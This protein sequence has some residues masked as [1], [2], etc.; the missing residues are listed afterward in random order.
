MILFLESKLNILYP[1][2]RQSGSNRPY[3]IT[4]YVG[5]VVNY[6]DFRPAIMW[7]KSLCTVSPQERSIIERV[8]I[9]KW[10]FCQLLCSVVNLLLWKSRTLEQMFSKRPFSLICKKKKEIHSR[11]GM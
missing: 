7:Y 4:L 8:S 5:K 11:F 3:N 2:E 9:R 1:S 10:T 6:L